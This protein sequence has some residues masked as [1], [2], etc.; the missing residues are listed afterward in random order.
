MCHGGIGIDEERVRE[1]ERETVM[2][3]GGIQ[4]VGSKGIIVVEVVEMEIVIEREKEKET[5][6]GK[7]RGKGEVIAEI[8]TDPLP[9][10]LL[11]LRLLL[12]VVTL[13]VMEDYRAVVEA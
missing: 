5:E 11:L 8:E 2:R 12:H 3:I 9:L 13:V 6:R 7:E 10:L 4:V 1:I